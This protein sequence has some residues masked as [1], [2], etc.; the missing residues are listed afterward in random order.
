M[1]RSYLPLVVDE[2]LEAFGEVHEDVFEGLELEE[3]LGVVSL[4]GVVLFLELLQVLLELFVL[5]VEQ[6]FFFPQLLETRSLFGQL[7][8]AGFEL[9]VL[10]HEFLHGL[11]QQLVLAFEVAQLRFGL[12]EAWLGVFCQLRGW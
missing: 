6:V 11:G 1:S 12:L 8:E 3:D 2:R 5:P 9:R 10:L 4:E 7:L